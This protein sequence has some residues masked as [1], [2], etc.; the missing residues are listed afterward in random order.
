[1]T[2]RERQRA[3]RAVGSGR[4]D[5]DE[6]AVRDSAGVPG[7]GWGATRHRRRG[8]CGPRHQDHH[9]AAQPGRDRHHRPFRPGPGE[10]RGADQAED[11]GR[12][13]RLDEHYRP[14]PE[15]R[16]ATAARRGHPGYRRGRPGR[17]GPGRR[18]RGG[19]AGRGDAVPRGSGGGQGDA[20]DPGV[21]RGGPDRGP[22]PGRRADRVVRGEHAGVPPPRARPAHR[23]H[24]GS[25]D[26]DGHGRAACPGRGARLPLPRG[27][28][29]PAALYPRVQ[30]GHG[31]GGRRRGRLDRGGLPAR[32]HL[33]RHGLGVRRGASL[34]RGTHRAR[35]PGRPR[36]GTGPGARARPGR[37]HLSRAGDQRGCRAVGGRRQGREPDRRRGHPPH[38][39]GVSRQGP[40]GH[41][42]Y[43]HYAPAGGRETG[44]RT[45]R[46]PALPEPDF[47]LV[48]ADT[49]PGRGRDR[50]RGRAVLA[51]RTRPGQ[52]LRSDLALVYRKTLVID[53]RYHLVSIVAVF[54]ALAIGIVLGSTELQGPTYNLLNQTTAKL[55]NELNQAS[56]QRDAAQQQANLG[57]NYAQAVEPVV[58]H[59]LLAGQRLLIITEPGA[60][61]SVV[62]AISNAA[63]QDAGATVTGQI[64]LQPKFFDKS[65]TTQDSLNTVN[66]DIAQADNI[67]LNTG[68]PSQQQ[69]AQVIASEILTRAST[70]GQVGGQ[71]VS[72]QPSTSSSAGSL[73][74]TNAQTMLGTYA[75]EGFLTISGH[76]AAPA[77]LAVIVTP[78]TAPQD[79]STDLLDQLLVPVAEEVAAKSSATVVVGVSAG[80]GPGSPIA[81]LRASSAASKV[82]TVD[83]ADF[84]AG[85]SV[86]IQALAMQLNGGSP[87]SYGFANGASAVG[88]SPAPTPSSSPS[89]SAST[90]PTSKKPK[91]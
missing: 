24:R 20:A 51:G 87:G 55:Q 3:V 77:T 69:A 88:P 74:D 72:T 15:P 39:G 2:R 54:L 11:R 10:R 68:T 31:G 34:R 80:S 67:V 19:P 57:Q 23:R 35:L 7:S 43:L 61:A 4:M 75:T 62:T 41:V 28:G 44:Q 66:M 46:A 89:P 5:S 37:D 86:V 79:G 36:A 17:D 9:Q 8:A 90:T 26:G 12:G 84:V 25:P 1:M 58:L 83:D 50:A 60:P 82:S 70:V 27:P 29:R 48:A 40:A 32:C 85:Q 22:V 71:Q 52:V 64:A 38:A 63:T 14:L 42:E 53:F 91:K 81:V 47:R 16:S 21:D 30:A 49:G 76:P 73:Q 78:Q 56:S 13:Q 65:G 59:N 45:G 6:V 33:R 18:R